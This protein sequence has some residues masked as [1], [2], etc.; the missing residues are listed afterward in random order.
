MCVVK[1][2]RASVY[3]RAFVC[4]VCRCAC[5]PLC[6]SLCPCASRVRP[7]V[8]VRHYACMSV[9]ERHYASVCVRHCASVSVC[10]TVTVWLC[11][12]VCLC[13][14]VQVPM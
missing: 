3:A 9:R 7:S 10:I 8:C 14:F 11:A 4:V 5:V 2:M 6:S 13:E 12:S 1:H